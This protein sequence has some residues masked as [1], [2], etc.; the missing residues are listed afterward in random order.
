VRFLDGRRLA[1]GYADGA[2]E[3]RDLDYLFRYAAGQTEYQ[4]KLFGDRGV[5]FPRAAEVLA[6]ARSVA[7]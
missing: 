2:V 5:Q 7:K 4:L 6:W 3:V 1:I